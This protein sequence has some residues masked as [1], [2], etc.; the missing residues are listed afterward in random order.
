QERDDLNRQPAGAA[1]QVLNSQ[2]GQRGGARS[3][4]SDAACADAAGVAE[5]CGSGAAGGAGGGAGDG[6]QVVCALGD[7]GGAAV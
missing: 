6:V 1:P 2:Y 4:G 7:A 5:H 3:S